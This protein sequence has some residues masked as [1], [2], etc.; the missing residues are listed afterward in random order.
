MFCSRPLKQTNGD[1]AIPVFYVDSSQRIPDI[2]VLK[3]AFHVEILF[4]M[5]DV[6]GIVASAD[7]QFST[8]ICHRYGTEGIGNRNGIA[9]IVHTHAAILI[10]DFH[11]PVMPV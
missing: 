10:L 6:D 9:D 11:R 8:N 4:D 1:F 7:L 2:D 5:V 3:C